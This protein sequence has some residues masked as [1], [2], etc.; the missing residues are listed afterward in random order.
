MEGVP[1]GARSATVGTPSTPGGG[2]QQ[3]GQSW[4]LHR[5]LSVVQRFKAGV[6]HLCPTPSSSYPYFPGASG[7]LLQHYRR[8]LFFVPFPAGVKSTI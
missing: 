6:V 1:E 7:F 8:L 5:K 4:S 2:K 3:E